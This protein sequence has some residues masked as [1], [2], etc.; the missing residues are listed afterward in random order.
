VRQRRGRD[1]L[2][3][4]LPL[5]VMAAFNWLGFWPQGPFRSNVFSLVYA[6]GVAAVAFEGDGRRTRF[7]DLAPAGLLV[8]LPLLVFE[9]TWHRQKE[10]LSMTRPAAFPDAL[11]ELLRLQGPHSGRREQLVMDTYGC[12]PYRYYTK[13]H[14]LSKTL[15]KKIL[16]RF[17]LRCSG[18]KDRTA[19]VLAATRRALR[20]D[21]RTWILASHDGVIEDLDQSWP[22]DLEK[23]ALSRIGA[24]THVLIGVKHKVAPVIPPTPLEEEHPSAEGDSEGYDGP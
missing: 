21:A 13:Y 12:Q 5:G 4:V 1:A 10:M 3:L 9:K 23:V 6:A 7:A 14:P 17:E 24:N 22:D 20:R 2:L 19:A 11:E 16:H 8:L 15:G 18:R